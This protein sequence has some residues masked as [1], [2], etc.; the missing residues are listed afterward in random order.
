MQKIFRNVQSRRFYGQVGFF[1]CKLDLKEC[2]RYAENSHNRPIPE[3]A[4]FTHDAHTKFS[5]VFRP[6]KILYEKQLFGLVK[7]I[8]DDHPHKKSI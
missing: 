4:I 6:R 2:Y 7:N 3:P 1:L 5:Y 8:F